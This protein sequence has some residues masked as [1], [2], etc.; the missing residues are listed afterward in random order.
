MSVLAGKHGIVSEVFAT[1]ASIEMKSYVPQVKL[2]KRI[3]VLSLDV[4]VLEGTTNY[5]V[6]ANRRQTA[7]RVISLTS[8]YFSA[9]DSQVASKLTEFLPGD[10]ISQ[11]GVFACP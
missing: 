5:L 4:L 8:D 1:V 6:L 7:Q 11:E 9:V 10:K 2:K 3:A